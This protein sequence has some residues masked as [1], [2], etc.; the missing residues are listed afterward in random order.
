MFVGWTLHTAEDEIVGVI[1]P[2]LPHHL[3]RFLKERKKVF[4]K[5]LCQDVPPEKLLVGS[6]LF[7][8]QSRSNKEIVGEARIGQISDGTVE[9]V[10]AKFG[11]DLFLTR[12]ELELYAGNRIRKRMLVLVLEEVKH[13]TAP[14]K[15][16]RSVTMAGQYMTRNMLSNLKAGCES[17]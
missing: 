12:N 16:G 4:V 5:Y 1:F 10:L 8:Y 7:F 11:N 13:Y 15:L 9:E 2:I 6:K 17:R 14:L 3:Q